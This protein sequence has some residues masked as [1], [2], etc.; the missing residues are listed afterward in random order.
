[1]P[2]TGSS[3]WP[4]FGLEAKRNRYRCAPRLTGFGIIDTP[5]AGIYD[6]GHLIWF[7]IIIE[8]EQKEA[9]QE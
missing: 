2:D 4:I 8:G 7:S 9:V 3:F 6:S 5:V 1:M